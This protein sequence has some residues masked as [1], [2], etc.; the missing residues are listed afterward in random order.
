M[1]RGA[2]TMQDL[3]N[4]EN[5]QR[6]AE[7]SLG[8]AILTARSTLVG[9]QALKVLLAVRRY[10]RSEMEIRA[11]IPSV[12]PEGITGGLTYALSKRKVS[13]GQML[14][15]G[16]AVDELVIENPLRLWVDVPE[17]YSSDVKLDQTVAV[18]VSAHSGM[19]FEGKVARINPT[20]DDK[21]RT[22]QVEAAIPNNGG[23]LR[24]GGFAKAAIV[25]S[26]DS[27]AA[28]V[29][30]D[31]VTSYAGVTKIFVVEQGKAHAI[32]VET[33]VQGKGW[34]EVIGTLPE[35]AQV[36][37]TGQAHLAEGTDVVVRETEPDRSG[38]AGGKEAT[39]R[40]ASAGS[41]DES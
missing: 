3:Q 8:A 24:P 12:R 36:V 15:A 25:T 34:I 22:F 31:S 16:D 2:G 7:A 1:Q 23:L 9:A 13:E 39:A 33:G 17:R 38:T 28:V 5:D 21:S 30:I 41:E 27:K 14:K 19:T 4:A 20:V 35:A 29:P 18:T 6:G 40:T 26:R 32:P 37:K 11:P 10:R